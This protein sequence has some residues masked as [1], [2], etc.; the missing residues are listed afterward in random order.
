MGKLMQQIASPEVLN[1]SWKRHRNDR[2]VWSENMS[3]R[4]MEKDIVFHLT[5]L[6]NELKS[7]SY[8]PSNVRFSTVSKADGKKRIISALTLRDKVAQ[9]SVLTVIEKF[10]EK[11]FHPDSYAYRKGRSIDM[12]VS[13]AREYIL[14]DLFWL[15]DADIHK[16]FDEIPHKQLKKSIA[17]IIPDKS[18][19]KLIFR[20]IDIGTPKT[21]LMQKRKG[22]PQGSI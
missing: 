5:T 14:C 21:G 9:R 7:G 4:E 13:K 1:D 15:V 17:K 12:A 11:I 6:A 22:I 3:R 20:W 16:F 2:A 19:Q 18:V 10:G 8:K